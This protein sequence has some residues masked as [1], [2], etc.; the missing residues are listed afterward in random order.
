MIATL[1]L[2]LVLYSCFIK[3]IQIGVFVFVALYLKD[4]LDM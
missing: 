2:Y 4:I 1:R 3:E